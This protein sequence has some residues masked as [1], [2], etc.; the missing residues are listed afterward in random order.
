MEQAAAEPQPQAPP[1]PPGP[2]GPRAP[3]H[4]PQ[5]P[6]PKHDSQKE[7]F[8]QNFRSKLSLKTFRSKHFVQSLLAPKPLTI[9]ITSPGHWKGVYSTYMKGSES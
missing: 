3:G 8:G 1:G 9:S 2:L 6:V 4:R 5:A 7:N